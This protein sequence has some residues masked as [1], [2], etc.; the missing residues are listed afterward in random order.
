MLNQELTK[1]NHVDD[2]NKE[3]VPNKSKSPD[4][5]SSS[6]TSTIPGNE[7]NSD[8]QSSGSTS[9]S[10]VRGKPSACVFVASLCASKND[11]DLCIS[12]TNHFKQFGQL[13]S[14]KVLR[15]TSNRPYAFVQYTNENDSNNAIDK[16]H[17]SILDD[18]ILRCE[19][20]KVNRTLFINFKQMFSQ[21]D[22]IQL[23][24]KFG[25]IEQTYMSTVSGKLLNDNGL[26]K[27]WFIK[28]VYRDDAIRCFANLTV[29]SNYSVEWAKNIESNN[30]KTYNSYKQEN[31]ESSARFDK[32]SIFVGQLNP[33]I[34]ESELSERFERHGKIELISLI[35]R[36]TNTFA[37]IKY[38]SEVGAARAVEVENHALF[39]NKTIHVQYREYHDYRKKLNKINDDNQNRNIMLAPPPINVIKKSNRRLEYIPSNDNFNRPR[40]SY[41]PRSNDKTP[42]MFNP[43]KFRTQSQELSPSPSPHNYIGSLK[44]PPRGQQPFYYF[45]PS[46][47]NYSY[48]SYPYY[49]YD[50]NTYPMVQYPMFYQDQKMKDEL[51]K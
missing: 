51:Q 1:L 8:T 23:L 11:D 50:E 37:F 15:D 4:K 17:N 25:E 21:Q 32:F 40:K 12:V 2:S 30:E 20:A 38:A 28:F 29:S 13:S 42:S 22:L 34:T 46:E 9:Y 33:D 47:S 27:Y 19:P 31:F 10:S 45:V 7:S 26:S 43:P 6:T 41:V 5:L 16:G 39:M 49:M 36:A 18:R 44:S 24:K 14:V 48:S 35:K 3:N